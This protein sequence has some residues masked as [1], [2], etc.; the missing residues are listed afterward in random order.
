MTGAISS[1][2]ETGHSMEAE[3]NE[4]LRFHRSERHLHWAIALPFMVCYATAVILVTVYNPYPGRPFRPIFSWIHRLSGMC[5][6]M[7]PLWTAV[8]HWRDLALH[9]R[10]VRHAWSWRL[11]DL[12]WL[13]L[14]GP[15][16]LNRRIELPPQH[17]FNAGEKINFMAVSATYPL[18]IFTGLLIWLHTAVYLSWLA[19]FSL[20]LATTPLVVGHIMMATVNPDTRPGLPGMISGFVDRHW[21][22]H[23]YRLW[24][25]EHY[26]SDIARTTA[27]LSQIDATA[28]GG[29]SRESGPRANAARWLVVE[30]AGASLSRHADAETDAGVPTGGAIGTGRSPDAPVRDAKPAIGMATPQVAP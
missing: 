17:K 19:H 6:V 24:Y 21:A 10:N 23:H 27:Q 1:P 14:F 8:R 16:S 12:K 22:K 18:L 20:A 15:S 29:S 26:G 28:V 13:L 3:T 2:G 9:L 4:I 30:S 25:D 11:D 5:L 7:L